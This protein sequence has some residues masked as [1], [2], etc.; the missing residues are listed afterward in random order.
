MREVPG[1]IPGAALCL[2]VWL[3]LKSPDAVGL[4]KVRPKSAIVRH[5]PEWPKLAGVKPREFP[6]RGLES[7]RFAAP[8]LA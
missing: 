6:L 2:L 7:E 1:S 4:V 3:P 5:T 8:V